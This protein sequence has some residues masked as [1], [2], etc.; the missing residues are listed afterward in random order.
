MMCDPSV[1][2]SGNFSHVHDL[3]SDSR[4]VNK[5]FHCKFFI[6]KKNIDN[7]KEEKD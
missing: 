3:R 1:V 6:S 2:L 5:D 4:H 7:S